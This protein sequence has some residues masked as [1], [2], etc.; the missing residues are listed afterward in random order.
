MTP[1]KLREVYDS[2]SDHDA[3]LAALFA[4]GVST[5]L[6]AVDSLPDEYPE[7]SESIRVLLDMLDPPLP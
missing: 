3:G 2:A 7:A 1:A 6:A 5:A 4:Y